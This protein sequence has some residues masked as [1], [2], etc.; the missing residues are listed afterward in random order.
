MTSKFPP[1][2]CTL[3]PA[4]VGQVSEAAVAEAKGGNLAREM[5]WNEV[6]RSMDWHT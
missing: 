3:H 4:R 1:F 5:N 6:K 2:P